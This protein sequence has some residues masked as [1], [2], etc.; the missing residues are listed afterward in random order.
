M[1]RRPR[2]LEGMLT[3]TDC[4]NILHYFSSNVE[5]LKKSDKSILRTLPFYEATHGELV[6]LKNHKV[7]VV[8]DD[9]P[10]KELKESGKSGRRGISEFPAIVVFII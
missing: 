9:L 6:D 10:R 1:M 8:P 2:S 3:T 4:D 7:Y 5:R